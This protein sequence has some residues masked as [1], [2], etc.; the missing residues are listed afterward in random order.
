MGVYFSE[1]SFPVDPQKHEQVSGS[2]VLLKVADECSHVQSGLWSLL[3]LKYCPLGLSDDV[4]PANSKNVS[5]RTANLHFHIER[6]KK[7]GRKWARESRGRERGKLAGSVWAIY[8]LRVF[9][10]HPSSPNISLWNCWCTASFPFSRYQV[11]TW[12]WTRGR[13]MREERFTKRKQNDDDYWN[14]CSQRC[15][16][17]GL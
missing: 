10:I 9:S 2:S 17:S 16:L 14:I 15:R 12:G 5:R 1:H 8:L 7:R 4:V 3:S 11:S 13:R 6:E